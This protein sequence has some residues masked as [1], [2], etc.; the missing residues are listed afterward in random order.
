MQVEV[1][2][3]GGRYAERVLKY[4]DAKAP[5]TITGY[6][7]PS[8]L[9]PTLDDPSEYLP[10]ALGAGD[11]IIAINLHP[12]LLLEIPHVVAGGTTR[13]MIAPIEDPAWIRP[14]L[15]RQV[16]QIC[17]QN[18]MES[19]FPKPFCALE[20]ATPAIKEFGQIYHVGRPRLRFRL[21]E[22]KVAQ[23]GISR[24]SPCGLT[25]WVVKQLVGKPADEHLRE[26]AAQLH[27]AYPCFATMNLD[28]ETKDT[29]MH[30]SADLL[31]DEVAR[32]LEEAQRA[33]AAPPG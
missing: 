32:A 29:I 22:G 6:Q 28:P 13:A 1:V 14:G 18:E 27:H 20:P 5:G 26:I 3:I 19:A 8:S 24:G 21:A 9:P 4:L 30:R 33:A 16:T 15:Q 11:I 23:V 12:E 2:H 10:E 25:E 7:V 31:R 17:A